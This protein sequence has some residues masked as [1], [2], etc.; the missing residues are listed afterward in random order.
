M[1]PNND[2]PEVKVQIGKNI[3]SF[4]ESDSDQV[5]ALPKMF[6]RLAEVALGLI[7]ISLPFISI[8]DGKDG[9]TTETG[10]GILKK[11]IS[12]ERKKEIEIEK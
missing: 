2:K 7:I 12:Q 4:F 3:E 10:S 6:T 9:S 8:N 5:K 11:I 1:N